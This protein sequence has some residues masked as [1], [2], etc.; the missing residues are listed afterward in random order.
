[1]RVAAGAFAKKYLAEKHDIK[2]IGYLAQMGDIV[3][4]RIDLEEIDANPFFCPDKSKLLKME[5][6]IDRLRSK[7]D[8]VEREL[9][10]WSRMFLS[11][12]EPLCLGSLMLT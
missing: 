11:G 2:I 8:S 7:G 6:L 9:R 10:W 12:W 3:V 1:M 4:D 5:E